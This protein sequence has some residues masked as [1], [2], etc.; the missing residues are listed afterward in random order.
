METETF[1][2]QKSWIWFF[3][4]LKKLKFYKF[5]DHVKQAD[6]EWLLQYAA[7]VFTPFLLLYNL[8]FTFLFVFILIDGSFS[9]FIL[10]K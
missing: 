5:A 4:I 9:T 3:S 1:V 7:E 8:K 6:F 10:T 2:K